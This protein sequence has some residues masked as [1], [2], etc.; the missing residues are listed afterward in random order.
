MAEEY[1]MNMLEK[2]TLVIGS[3]AMIAGTGGG[4]ILN[5]VKENPDYFRQL[6][7]PA[8]IIGLTS[9]L[10]GI[11]SYVNRTGASD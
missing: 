9:S 4:L 11:I 3:S 8:G 10:I 2:I 5:Y 6:A 1:S 7:L